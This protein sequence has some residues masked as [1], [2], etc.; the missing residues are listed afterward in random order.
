MHNMLE[1]FNKEVAELQ[2]VVDKRKAQGE[3]R[4]ASEEIP[5]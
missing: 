3:Q 2:G 5:K 4:V 1:M